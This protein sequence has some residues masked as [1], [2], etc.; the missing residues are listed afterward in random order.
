MTLSL[1]SISTW[2]H[3]QGRDNSTTGR[4]F[5][6]AFYRMP[7]RY[8]YS[9]VG[10][11]TSHF[12]VSSLQ[13]SYHWLYRDIIVSR[14][15]SGF[16]PSGGFGRANLR[17]ASEVGLTF[18]GWMT[19]GDL[20]AGPCRRVGS[21]CENEVQASFTPQYTWQTGY[22]CGWNWG[23]V[24]VYPTWAV[25]HLHAHT[26]TG[27]WNVGIFITTGLPQWCPHRGVLLPRSV[28]LLSSHYTTSWNYCYLPRSVLLSSHYLLEHLK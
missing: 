28:L 15:W 1:L 18:V 22:L 4:C 16:W 5:P 10:L 21:R 8:P 12:Q 13:V 23:R 6:S 19:A 25:G 7:D 17:R 11:T 26:H 14:G 3:H 9:T 20:S 27:G 2:C 24:I